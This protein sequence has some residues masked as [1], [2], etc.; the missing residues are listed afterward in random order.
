MYVDPSGH[1]VDPFTIT[2]IF[3]T[4]A[5]AVFSGMKAGS[6]TNWHMKDVAIAVNL[7]LLASG[8]SYGSYLS[9]V[10]DCVIGAVI[11]TVA[12]STIPAGLNAAYYGGNVGNAMLKSLAITAATTAASMIIG[13]AIKGFQ[14]AEITGEIR[15]NASSESV[16]SAEGRNV[17]LYGCSRK[18]ELPGINEALELVGKEPLHSYG[19]LVDHN[20]GKVIDSIGTDR[21]SGIDFRRPEAGP[22]VNKDCHFMANSRTAANQINTFWNHMVLHRNP[23][24]Y[25]PK[26]WDCYWAFDNAANAANLS[27]PLSG[28]IGELGAGYV[29]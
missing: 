11:A 8:L 14:S 3:F 24:I 23:I 17:D 5:S 18:T 4:V 26:V 27:N 2:A 12:A 10:A 19:V 16:V 6:D 9:F 7:S 13:A 28:R 22:D 21:S 25:V 20:T 15:S 1:Y 29:R